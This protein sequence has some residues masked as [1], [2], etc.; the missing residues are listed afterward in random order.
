LA[1][2]IS[3]FLTRLFSPGKLGGYSTTLIRCVLGF[4]KP[5]TILRQ[6]YLI[7][8]IGSG[9]QV[10][11]FRDNWI[12]RPGALSVIAH[13]GNS[14]RRWVSELIDHS[15]HTWDEGA[16]RSC[17]SVY[18]AKVIL[19]IKLPPRQC[20]D[21]VAWYPESNGLFSVRPAYR[22]GM[23]P[24]YEALSRVSRVQNLRGTAAYGTLCGRLKSQNLCL[25]LEGGDLLASC[26]IGPPR[27]HSNY[28]PGLLYLFPRGR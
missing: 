21:F 15:T 12:P 26:E 18:D 16:V 9:S 4:S 5:G 13:R 7:L 23:E 3:V 8:R 20:E 14:R 2:E 24:S 22:L 19:S 25:C 6:A 28:R 27:E 1:F 11:I 10:K 17:C